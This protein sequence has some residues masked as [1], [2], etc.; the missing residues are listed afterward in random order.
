M[1][2]MM[3]GDPVAW[4]LAGGVVSGMSVMVRVIVSE[5][6]LLCWSV[7]VSVRVMVALERLTG[8]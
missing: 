6:V 5:A 4:L 1:V 3:A 7:A 8:R 2:P